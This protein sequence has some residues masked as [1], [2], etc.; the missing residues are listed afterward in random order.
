VTVADRLLAETPEGSVTAV[1]G[2]PG[3]GVS[4]LLQGVCSVAAAAS[5][6]LVL[7]SWERPPLP[8]HDLSRGIA[9]PGVIGWSS[10][11][12][13]RCEPVDTAGPGVVVAVDYL[14]L[15]ADGGDAGEALRSLARQRRWRLVLGVMA[16]R[17]LGELASGVSPARAVRRAVQVLGGTLQHVDRALVLTGADRDA[18][19]ASLG[20]RVGRSDGW[21]LGWSTRVGEWSA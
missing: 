4:M 11:E 20:V 7:A 16:P 17:E 14:Q 1:M 18:R 2:R 12:L 3:A 9:Q 13:A 15:L 5:G 10:D 19:S 21:R 6:P 8:A